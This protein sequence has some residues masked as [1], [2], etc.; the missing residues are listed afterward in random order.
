MVPESTAWRI[1]CRQVTFE[2]CLKK[3]QISIP[4]H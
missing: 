1:N 3:G 4:S 2:A